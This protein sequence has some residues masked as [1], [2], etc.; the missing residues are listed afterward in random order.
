MVFLRLL[1][2]SDLAFATLTGTVTK[3]PAFSQPAA[4]AEVDPRASTIREVL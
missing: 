3:E 4:D 1:S 2:T